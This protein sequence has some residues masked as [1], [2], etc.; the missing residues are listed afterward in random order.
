MKKSSFLFPLQ[1]I[2]VEA[3]AQKQFTDSATGM[4]PVDL[5][6]LVSQKVFLAV[7]IFTILCTLCLVHLKVVMSF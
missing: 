5:G 3:V 6:Q 2:I 7:R 4:H 1:L